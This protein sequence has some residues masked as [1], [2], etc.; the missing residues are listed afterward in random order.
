MDTRENPSVLYVS[1]KSTF[2]LLCP[3]TRRENMMYTFQQGY[4]N[5]VDRLNNTTIQ[6]TSVTPRVRLCARELI[7][8]MCVYLYRYVI[9]WGNLL[10]ALNIMIALYYDLL[11][12]QQSNVP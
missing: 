8:L 12:L 5:L 7:C 2:H 9:L 3:L 10:M 1:D 11:S 6:R 4:I